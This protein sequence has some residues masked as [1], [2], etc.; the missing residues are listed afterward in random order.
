[1]TWS[2]TNC[3]P[4]PIIPIS[5]FPSLPYLLYYILLV[6]SQ[7]LE[8]TKAFLTRV[9]LCLLFPLP[10]KVFLLF[11]WLVSYPLRIRNTHLN[12]IFLRIAF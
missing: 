1:M 9:L 3:P 6:L 4:L 8:Q 11:L 12:V 5:L 2:L 10:K 7:I